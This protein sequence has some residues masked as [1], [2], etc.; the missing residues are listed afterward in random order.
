MRGTRGLSI[1]YTLIP[2]AC[3]HR[4]SG[5]HIRQATH[6]RVTTLTKVAG[7]QSMYIHTM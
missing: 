1:K 2:W 5:V 3:G 7:Q 6:V 4:D